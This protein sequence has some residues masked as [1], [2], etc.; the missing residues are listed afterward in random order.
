MKINRVGSWGRGGGSR[1]GERA[2]NWIEMTVEVGGV[3][4]RRKNCKKQR[5]RWMGHEW[6][7]ITPLHRVSGKKYR[8]YPLH[9]LNLL[10]SSAAI[11]VISL[12][13]WDNEDFCLPGSALIPQPSHTRTHCCI[14][15]SA[16]SGG[17]FD[18]AVNSLWLHS[19][20]SYCVNSF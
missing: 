15:F 2:L 10:L 6:F 14:Q 4:H 3:D 1:K 17:G 11:F 5:K 12:T 8:L 7:K 16:T 18:K 9:L 13:I 19:I 20:I